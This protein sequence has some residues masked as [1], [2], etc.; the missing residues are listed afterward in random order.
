MNPI[1]NSQGGSSVLDI[2]ENT[3]GVGEQLGKVGI[4]LMQYTRT[5]HNSRNN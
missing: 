2:D 3:P 1:R 4:N 5:K